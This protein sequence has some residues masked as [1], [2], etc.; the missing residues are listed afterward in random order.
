MPLGEAAGDDH[1]AR[2]P[3]FFQI[4]HLADDPIRLLPRGIDEGAGVDDDEIG[5]L[6][7]GDQLPAVLA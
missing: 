2:P 3:G 1:A 6:G 7:L 4:E 5:P